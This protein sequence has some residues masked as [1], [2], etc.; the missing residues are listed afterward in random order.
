MD[1]SKLNKIKIKM[2]LVIN[3]IKDDKKFKKKEIDLLLKFNKDEDL[4]KLI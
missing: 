3:I 4:E 2:I 1:Y